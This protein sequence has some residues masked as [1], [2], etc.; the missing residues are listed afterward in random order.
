[1]LTNLITR[2]GHVSMSKAREKMRSFIAAVAALIASQFA[3]LAFWRIWV[4]LLIGLIIVTGV[5]IALLPT[6]FPVW[7]GLIALVI[8]GFFGLVWERHAKL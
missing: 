8:A 2:L 5:Y 4:S 3:D 1:M 6:V 7:P